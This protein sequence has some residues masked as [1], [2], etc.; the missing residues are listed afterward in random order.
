MDM[1]AD[2]DTTL[3]WFIVELINGHFPHPRERFEDAEDWDPVLGTSGCVVNCGP[4]G[5]L[6]TMAAT[7]DGR[8]EMERLIRLT[9][10]HTGGWAYWSRRTNGLKWEW[11]N[12]FWDGHL[13]CGAVG[14]QPTGCRF[15]YGDQCQSC[16]RPI[17]LCPTNLPE[18]AD[19][20][21]LEFESC[22][23]VYAVWRDDE[24]SAVA[25]YPVGDG[26]K[27]WCQYGR[28][29]PQ[30]WAELQTDFGACALALAAR[31]VVDPRDVGVHDRWP[32]AVYARTG[33]WPPAG[34]L[35]PDL[36]ADNPGYQH[37][38]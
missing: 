24:T 15:E 30:T 2:R 11:F 13:S 16:G 3:G 37:T 35:R 8:T 5:A 4:C 25:G 22:T 31:L 12:A 1:L 19:Q 26:G 20:T 23:D 7:E 27:T 34:Q 21:R 6:K 38:S 28:T 9:D 10:Y 32:T 14:G 29:V 33:A 36:D 17:K 18:P